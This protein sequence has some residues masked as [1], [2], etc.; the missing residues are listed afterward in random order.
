[1]EAE[2]NSET[3]V[4]FQTTRRNNPEDSNLHTRRRENQKSHNISSD[5][6][7]QTLQQNTYIVI[8]K[9]RVTLTYIHI[10]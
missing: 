8:L 5:L 4:S 2:S 7:M 10:F 6:Y 3:S 1:M 9:Y